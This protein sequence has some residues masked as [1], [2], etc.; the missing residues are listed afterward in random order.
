M[1]PETKDNV[2]MFQ[3]FERSITANVEHYIQSN[4]YSDNKIKADLYV[5]SL[6]NLHDKNLRN[7]N[8]LRK[9][10][11]YILH[12]NN[13]INNNNNKKGT[14]NRELNRLTDREARFKQDHQGTRHTTQPVSPD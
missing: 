10:F 3:S 12:Q 2:K 5:K 13:E 8:Y 6:I 4:D 1:A 11:E 14:G 7:Y 9:L